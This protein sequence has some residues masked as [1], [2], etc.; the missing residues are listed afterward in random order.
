[1]NNYQPN[2]FEWKFAW[3]EPAFNYIGKAFVCG[4]IGLFTFVGA[5]AAVVSQAVKESRRA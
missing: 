4:V 1:M 2:D 3:V 5:A